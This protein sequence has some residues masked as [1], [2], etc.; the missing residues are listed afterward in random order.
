MAEQLTPDEE[1]I[2]KT[3]KENDGKMNYKELQS[4]AEDKFE[5]LRLI[6]KKMKEKAIVDYDGVLPG[7]ASDILLSKKE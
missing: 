1:F 5:G 2:I 4:L 3:L 6:L 7:Y